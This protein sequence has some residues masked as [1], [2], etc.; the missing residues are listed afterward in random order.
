MVFYKKHIM[1]KIIYRGRLGNNLF[2]YCL[3][4]ILAIELGY[5]LIADPIP[6][7]PGTGDLVDG[8]EFAEPVNELC[9]QRINFHDQ[10]N[11]RECR[12]VVLNGC[13]QRDEYYKQHKRKIRKWLEIEP[14]DSFFQNNY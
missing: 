14:I 7:F 1:I 6:G 9:G 8:R 10:L 3:G 12:K 11:N 13:F 2:Q 4:R 5:K